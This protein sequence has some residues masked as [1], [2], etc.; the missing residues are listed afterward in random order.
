M[1][2]GTK[3]Y[4]TTRGTV[5]ELVDTTEDTH[6]TMRSSDENT[7][8]YMIIK[9]QQTGLKHMFCHLKEGRARF[10][11][12]DVVRPERM[13][14]ESGH[15]GASTQQHLH[16]GIYKDDCQATNSWKLQSVP[17]ILSS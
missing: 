8:N 15:K 3:L 7:L 16:F 17:I 1:P 14:A 4:S 6:P 2:I 12:G 13:I 5:V 10:K 11:I 9:D